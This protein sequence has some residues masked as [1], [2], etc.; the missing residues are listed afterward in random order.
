MNQ[1]ELF[2]EEEINKTLIM[3]TEGRL[4]KLF[5]A[6]VDF[7]QIVQKKIQ[8]IGYEVPKKPDDGSKS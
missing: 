1:G 6:G 3:E 4:G 8:E 2:S 7:H 5:N